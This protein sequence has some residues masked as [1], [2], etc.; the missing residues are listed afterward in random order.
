MRRFEVLADELAAQIRARVY[1]PGERLPSVRELRRQRGCS[2]TTASE[3]LAEL[4]RRGLAAARPRSGTYVLGSTTPPTPTPVRIPARHVSDD[5][6]AQSADPTVVPLGGAVLGSDLVPLDRLARLG[7]LALRDPDAA[8]ARYGAPAGDERLRVALARQLRARGVVREPQD[9]VVTAGGMD[10]LRLALG[11]VAQPGDVVAFGVPTFFGLIQLVRAVGYLALPLPMGP[12]GLDLAA[13]RRA[14]RAHPVKALI[15]TPTLHNPTGATT[16]ARHREALLAL[17]AEAGVDVVE[18]DVYGEL[19]DEPTPQPLAARDSRVLYCSSLSKTLAPGLRVGW[20]TCP[21]HTGTLVRARLASGITSPAWNQRVAERFLAEG[22]YT[23]HLRVL[24][25]RLAGQRTR[26]RAAVLRA[27]PAGTS[28]SEP[29]GGFL[30]WVTLPEAVD[31]LA[32]YRQGRARGLSFL[33]GPLCSLDGEPSRSLRLSAGHPW[34]PAIEEGVR[35]LGE[36]VT[37]PR[38]HPP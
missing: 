18:D 28:I 34:S 7:R 26:L 8:F 5:F 21:P 37:L 15:T 6:V 13:L 17:T 11:T 38:C 23:R 29:A 1:K 35:L 3:A 33:P 2:M 19:A 30:L 24:C 25:E 36:L 27:F 31:Q 4:E 10:A 12:A 22:R 14:V 32:V 16:S 20:V 9:I